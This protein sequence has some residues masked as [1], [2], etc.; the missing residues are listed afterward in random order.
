MDCDACYYKL[1][2]TINTHIRGDIRAEIGKVMTTSLTL[3]LFIKEPR[4]IFYLGSKIQLLVRLFIRK[5]NPF[6]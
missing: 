1:K 5:I 4:L 3:A 6:C 2:K